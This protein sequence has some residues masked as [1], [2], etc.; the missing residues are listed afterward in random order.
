MGIELTDLD[1]DKDEGREEEE[2]PAR[3]MLANKEIM[4]Q[5]C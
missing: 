3:G 2:A 5:V 4:Q 1:K